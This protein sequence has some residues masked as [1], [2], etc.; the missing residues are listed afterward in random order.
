[1]FSKIH[2]LDQRTR[3]DRHSW[4]YAIDNEKRIDALYGLHYGDERVKH[5]TERGTLYE[6]EH[7]RYCRYGTS[8]NVANGLQ[9]R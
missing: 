6:S 4:H 1:M 3:T 2:S 7:L 5:A 9:T 8:V